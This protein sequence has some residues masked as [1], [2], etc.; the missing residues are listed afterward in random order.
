LFRVLLGFMFATWFLS[1]CI[2]NTATTVM[3][4]PIA[5]A[6]NDQMI[7]FKVTVSRYA[8]PNAQAKISA[9]R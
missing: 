6:V 8:L 1:M 3:M 5:M 9:V 4:V 2:S 7:K